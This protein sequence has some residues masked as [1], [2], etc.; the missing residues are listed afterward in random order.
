MAYW[1]AARLLAQREHTALRFLASIF[2]GYFL[3]VIMS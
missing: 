3:V 2:G 1:C